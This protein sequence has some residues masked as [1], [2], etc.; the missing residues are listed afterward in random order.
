MKQ[1]L[2]LFPLLTFFVALKTY[3]LFI[4]TKLL[5]LTTALVLIFCWIKYRK[6]DKMELFSFI[7]VA[8]FGSLTIYL[9]DQ[10]FIIWKVTIFNGLLAFA[11]LVSPYFMKQTLLEKMLG[12][13]LSLP[14]KV[15]YHLNWIWIAF[16]SFIAL[17]NLYI[18]F[19]LSID[20]WAAFKSFGTP[21][22]SIIVTVI[23]GV[24]IYPFLPKEEKP[25]TDK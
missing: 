11:L 23:C 18:G 6:V 9:Q 10:R 12:K 7:L 5:I 8:I 20:I 16:F 4:A 25:N 17:I 19:S 14:A 21:I 15:W 2:Y 3:D 24:Y 1:L 13:E 22:A